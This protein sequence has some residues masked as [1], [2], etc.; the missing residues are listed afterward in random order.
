MSV[1]PSLPLRGKQPKGYVPLP[2]FFD[3]SFANLL[4]AY[5]C[6]GMPGRERGHQVP[7]TSKEVCDKNR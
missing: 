2:P 5:P 3:R 7:Q 6:V 1:T 4:W